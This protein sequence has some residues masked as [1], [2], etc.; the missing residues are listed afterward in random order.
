MDSAAEAY[1]RKETVLDYTPPTIACITSYECNIACVMC[2]QC[3][4]SERVVTDRAQTLIN[5]IKSLTWDRIDKVYL[6]GGEI[7]Y[8]A[9]GLALTEFLCGEDIKGTK[10]EMLTNGQTLDVWLE[11]LEKIDNF[12]LHISIEGCREAYNRVKKGADW[13]KLLWNLEKYAES[14]AKKPD[15][16]LVFTHIVMRSTYEYTQELLSLAQKHGAVSEFIAVEGY[17]DDENIFL[18]PWLTDRKKAVSGLSS[19][20]NTAVLHNNHPLTLFSLE[21]LIKLFDDSISAVWKTEYY[22]ERFKRI[23]IYPDFVLTPDDRLSDMLNHM[24]RYVNSA[25]A[26]GL[27]SEL[28]EMEDIR[29]YTQTY[30]EERY[31]YMTMLGLLKGRRVVVFGAGWQGSEIA[32]RNAAEG[33]GL[34]IAA[35]GEQNPE[36]IGTM[37]NGIPVIP[38][39][40][41]FVEG[42]AVLISSLKFEK[43]M[44]EYITSLNQE[45]PVVAVYHGRGVS[46]PY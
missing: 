6:S 43:S 39:E 37:L 8:S 24:D 30:Y 29:L 12:C 44:R 41:M 46:S 42:D 31:R 5:L 34:N 9:D 27:V 40:R 23:K 21:T 38:A 19:A 1:R 2:H 25:R 33:W 13:E 3:H 16:E 15:W 36:K 4:V 18:F 11:K 26:Q 35:F 22:L 14:R 32:E 10:V 20:L 45:N 7:L 28:K 17:F